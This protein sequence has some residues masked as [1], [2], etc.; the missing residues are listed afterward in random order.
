MKTFSSVLLILILLAQTTSLA[1]KRPVRAKHAMVVSADLYASKV[2]IEILKKGGNAVDAAVA[3]GFALAVSFPGA[4]NI[5]GGGFMVIRMADGRTTTIDYREKAPGAASR[6]MFL[7]ERGNF[8]PTKSEEGYLACGVPGSVAGLL[9]AL[10]RYGT[11]NRIKAMQP[12]IDLAAHGFRLSH[13]FVDDLKANTRELL[14]YPSSRKAFTKNG[15]PYVEGDILIQKDLAQTLQ[16]IRKLGK[17][18][19]YKGKT[20]DL[21]IAEMKRGGG[22][23]NHVDLESYQALERPPV[24]GTYRGYEVISMGPPSSGGMLV[25]EI[26]NLLE[27]YDIAEGGFGSSKTVGLMAEAMKVAYA[28]R[29]EFMGDADF[30]PVPTAQLI[31]KEYAAERRVFLQTTRATPS[32][33]IS[34]G[35]IN[36]KE[37]TNTT[38]YSIVDQWGNA[39]AVTTTLNGWYGN[40]VVVGGAGF[41]LNNEMDDFSAKPGVPNMYGVSGGEANS[42]QPSKRMLSTMTPTIV[43][44]DSQPY[45]VLGSPGGSTIATIV[46]QVIV[47]VLDHRMNVAEANDA[48]RFHHQWFP[49]TLRYERHGLSRDVIEN[50]E[51]RGYSV[52]LHGGT[53]GRVEAIL[54]DRKNGFLYGSTDPR[55]YGAAVGY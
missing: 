8:V 40:K 54:I 24:R 48:P 15:Q 28:D 9:L 17:D 52:R 30:Y 18:G 29:A 20:A 22:L 41:F 27:P 4:G 16:R 42:V 11:L 13:E 53:L 33:K 46:L 51:K 14:H 6:D 55:G 23:I 1:A 32:S 47:N 45:L 12:A 5:G 43:L 49:D 50:L 3:V 26:L 38:H 34:H 37:G 44:K 7:D 25:I 36:V 19:F 35:R 31:S 2:G 10:E 39:V 21:I